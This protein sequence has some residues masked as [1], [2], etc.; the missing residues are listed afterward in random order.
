MNSYIEI[1]N[2]KLMITLR[3]DLDMSFYDNIGFNPKFHFCK[4]IGKNMYRFYIKNNSNRD[5][6]IYT[7][8]LVFSIHYDDDLDIKYV[9]IQYL[10]ITPKRTGMGTKLMNTFITKLRKIEKLKKVYLSPKLDAIGF[11]NNIGFDES[12][13]IKILGDLKMINLMELDLKK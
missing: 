8:E 13:D 1:E 2:T 12:K 10:G 9:L 7:V 4:V 3:N 11:W 6:S 5:K